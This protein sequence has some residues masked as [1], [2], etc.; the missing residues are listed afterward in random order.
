MGVD[1]DTCGEK[2]GLEGHRDNSTN[3]LEEVES[4]PE[5]STDDLSIGERVMGLVSRRFLMETSLES[6]QV[7]KRRLDAAIA[8]RTRGAN[9]IAEI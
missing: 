9:T 1:V 8:L 6:L 3:A 7:L 2:S 5:N 4:I